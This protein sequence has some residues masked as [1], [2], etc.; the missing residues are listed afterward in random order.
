MRRKAI[1][2]A[3]WFVLRGGSYRST[4]RI[5]RTVLRNGFE[6]GFQ[7]KGYGFRLVAR[8]VR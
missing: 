8:K 4:A 3:R 5:L 1:K 6:S 2:N 7:C